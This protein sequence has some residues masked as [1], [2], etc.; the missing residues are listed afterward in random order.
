[1]YCISCG[2]PVPMHSRF[3]SRCGC[4]LSTEFHPAAAMA[5]A[6]RP[7]T[8]SSPA[9]LLGRE[10]GNCVGWFRNANRTIQIVCVL[11]GLFLIGITVI[12]FSNKSL[13][14]LAQHP[15]PTSKVHTIGGPAAQAPQ[16]TPSS[17]T[18]A[19]SLK[20]KGEHQPEIRI[21][22]F[23][24]QPRA[25]IETILGKPVRSSACSDAEGEQFEY[26][27]G[28]YLCVDRGRVILL[29]YSLRRVPS[30][31]NDALDAVGLHA[32]ADPYI[33]LGSIHIWS[34]Q[35]G[36]PFLIDK[37]HAHQ[38]TVFV[39]RVNSIELDMTGAKP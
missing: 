6:N 13:P 20:V 24:L 7:E 30:D 22:D 9:L 23:V 27:D 2:S 15:T 35:Y 33:L 34:D 19:S 1:M 14:Y 5:T 39:G 10:I 31:A 38:V 8:Y 32:L 29:S 16:Q 26:A 36:N 3:C 25:K 28:S 21:A 37:R 17:A 4:R 12:A 18:E 11:S